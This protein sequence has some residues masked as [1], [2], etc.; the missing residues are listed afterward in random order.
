[1]SRTLQEQ[2]CCKWPLQPLRAVLLLWLR[3][4]PFL[5]YVVV[6]NA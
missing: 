6:M 1:M 5:L 4:L 2:R 3:C